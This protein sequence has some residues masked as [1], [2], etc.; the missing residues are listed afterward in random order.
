M[1]PVYTPAGGPGPE[2][3][4]DP[5]G[6][7]VAEVV[8]TTTDPVRRA[9]QPGP[10]LLGD[11]A[12]G[13]DRA[14]V[15]AP[16]GVG[17][18]WATASSHQDHDEVE[19]IGTLSVPLGK[20]QR[21]APAVVAG[22]LVRHR[23]AQPAETSDT[24]ADPSTRRW[25]WSRGRC[26][27]PSCRWRSRSGPRATR[28]SSARDSSGSP[29]RTPP[30]VSSTTRR[31]T[32]SCCGRWARP[33][34]TCCSTGSRTAT[35]SAS[36]RSRC[37][38]PCGRRSSRRPPA[39]A[40]TSSRAAGTGSTP[41]AASRSS[42]SRRAVGSSS[43]T[44]WSVVRC[45]ASSSPRSRRVSAS[46][47]GHGVVTGYPMVD[48][49]VTLTDGKSHS[50]DSSDMAFQTAGGLALRDAATPCGTCL[51]EP[52]DEV[53]VLV[54]DDLVGTVM[55]DLSARR[56]KVLGSEP[57]GRAGHGRDQGRGAAAGAAPLLR[58]AALVLPRLGVVHAR[59]SPATSGSRTRSPPR[60]ADRAWL[61][62]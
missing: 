58:R 42:R 45:P 22:D 47:M 62:A 1:P 46:Q 18:R 11:R 36:T 54:A 12:A 7:L 50:V 27:I 21:P 56:G 48:L 15:R 38:C 2:L 49:R 31:P 5:S 44:A 24:L 34:P 6:P 57:A 29:P 19:R 17:R 3:A 8:K 35:A 60:F 9:G 59:R 37:G 16:L 52:V 30:C 41:C 33:T 10:G 13:R 61:G 43:S 40:G 28:T 25:C 55:G 23:T 4:C 39:T 26:P 20:T 53:E 32:R 14:R 51:L